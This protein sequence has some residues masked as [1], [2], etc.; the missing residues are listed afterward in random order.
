MKKLTPF[1]ILLPG[2]ILLSSCA[3]L[4]FI[5]A[6]DIPVQASIDTSKPFSNDEYA[7]LLA[8]YVTDEGWVNYTELQQNRGALDRYYAQLAAVTPDT[9]KS[10]STDKQLAYMMNAY[11]ALTLLAII[12]QEPLKGSIRDIPGVWSSKK[13]QVAGESK[14]LNNIEHDIIRPTFNEPRIHAALVCAAKSCPPLRNEPFT[15]ENVDAQ[16][17]DQVKRWLARPDSGFQIDRQE[18]KV[19]LS[20]IFDWYGDDWKP[21]F[22]VK[23]QFSGDDKQKAVLNFISNYVSAEDQAYLKAGKY[24]VSYLDYDWSLNQQ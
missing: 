18:N 10:W 17:E 12:E 24:Q 8:Q 23:D 4:P 7:K 14:T 3:N 16:L 15:A 13:F 20:K 2:V 1:S 11:N 21:D 5:G 19:Y 9:Y 22:A 6:E